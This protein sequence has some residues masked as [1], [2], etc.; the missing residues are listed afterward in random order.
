MQKKGTVLLSTSL[1]WPAVA[2]CSRAETISQLSSNKFTP[3]CNF[4]K[5]RT[6]PYSKAA[7]DS[8]VEVVLEF[9]EHQNEN[10]IVDREEGWD[11]MGKK[12]G[13]GPDILFLK[14]D[15]RILR[16]PS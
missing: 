2:G 4:D 8:F 6:H 11:L 15:S 13:K 3:L 16:H 12:G 10:V 14:Q 7:Q 9:V 5:T 1:A